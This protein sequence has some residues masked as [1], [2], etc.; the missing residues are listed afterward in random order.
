MEKKILIYLVD[1][2]NLI[3]KIP[4]LSLQQVDDEVQ[5]IKLLQIFARIRRASVEVFFDQAP[6]GYSG[7]KQV[8]M[9]KAHFVLKGTTADQEMI[10]HIQHMK[11]TARTITVV[12]SDRRIRVEAQAAHARL[13]SSEMFADM[14]MNAVVEAESNGGNSAAPLPGG[15]VDEWLHLFGAEDE[16]DK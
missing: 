11:K 16:R 3:P 14:V 2:H 1:G 12:T 13:L 10:F 6:P 4:G 15:G 7:L 5:L 8:G 9:L